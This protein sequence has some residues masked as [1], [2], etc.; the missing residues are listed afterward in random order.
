MTV[1]PQALVAIALIVGLTW[2]HVRGVGPGRVVQNILAGLKV[3]GLVALIV[4]G[5]SLGDGSWAHFEP[6]GVR[7]RAGGFLLALVPVM[8]SYSGWNAAS[9]VAEEI[10]HPERFVP[11][12]LAVGTGA[13]V[14][15]YLVAERALRLLAAGRRARR[16]RAA[17]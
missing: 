5:F 9:Y 2:I 4:F 6:A 12:S 1:T 15:L 14:A 8:F 10:R 3:T 11:R 13:V 17:A 7:S 16:A